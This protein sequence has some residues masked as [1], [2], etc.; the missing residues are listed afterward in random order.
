VTIIEKNL[1]ASMANLGAGLTCNPDMISFMSQYD[2]VPEPYFIETSGMRFLDVN[3]EDDP[4]K[5]W[6]GYRQKVT[7]WNTL[8]HRLRANFDGLESGYCDVPARREGDGE[9]RYMDGCTVENVEYQEGEETVKVVYRG[10][11]GEEKRIEGDLLIA[12]DGP[13]SQVR[14]I[15]QPDVERK[16]VGYIAWRGTVPENEISQRSRDLLGAAPIMCPIGNSCT[17]SSVSLNNPQLVIN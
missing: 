4:S 7:N 1:T 13:S 5:E 10:V 11:N 17:I 14:R 12:A 3:G 2:L 8:F 15:L 16:Y 6:P 9:A